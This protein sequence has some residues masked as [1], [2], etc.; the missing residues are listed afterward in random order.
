MES[1]WKADKMDTIGL[2]RGL[3]VRIILV[4]IFN[5]NSRGLFRCFNSHVRR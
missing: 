5:T 3:P 1:R 4:L 2:L